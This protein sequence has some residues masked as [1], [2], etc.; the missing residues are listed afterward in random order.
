M[1]HMS[2]CYVLINHTGRYFHRTTLS[3]FNSENLELKDIRSLPRRND[4]PK[5]DIATETNHLVNKSFPTWVQPFI[6]VIRCRKSEKKSKDERSEGRKKCRVPLI[7]TS[8]SLSQNLLY[9][10]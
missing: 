5:R 6:L 10:R 7:P 3:W 4:P 8:T 9:I 2:W 1:R